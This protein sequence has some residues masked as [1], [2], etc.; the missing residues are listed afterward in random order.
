VTAVN[1]GPA[2]A[3]CTNGGPPIN[4]PVNMT[5]ACTGNL[6]QT[7]FTWALC[8][9]NNVNGTDALQTDIYDSTKGPYPQAGP[10]GGSVGANGVLQSSSL[11]VIGGTLWTAGSTGISSTGSVNV[12]EE[13]HVNGPVNVRG[14]SVGYDAFVNGAVSGGTLS[15]G[16][17]LTVPNGVTP[18]G[19][20]VVGQTIHVPPPVSVPPPC[21]CAP[22]DIIPVAT[23]VAARAMNNDD[24][25]IGLNPSIVTG[26]TGGIRLDL[27]CGEYYLN[28]IT[29]SDPVAIV[30]HGHTALYIGSNISP[31]ATL[32]ITLDPTATLDLFV[33][34]T[35]NTS[36]TLTIGN[37]NYPALSRTY[38]GGSQALTFSSGVSLGTN[39]YAPNAHLDWGAGTDIY[40]SVFSGD[41][42]GSSKVAIHYDSAVLQQ[43]SSC[44]PPPGNCSSCQQCGNQAC[45]SGMCGS[46]MNSTQCCAP[47]FCVGGT[48]TTHE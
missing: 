27:P 47:L 10:L 31:S 35:I 15:I 2:P 19:T 16:K 9:C 18:T 21:R 44:G 37:I 33:A 39:F 48:C 23:I 29:N 13:L 41:F 11:V 12:K 34:G 38:I 22:S 26:P 25:A 1:L 46:C 45:N 24:A 7:T 20:A 36:N 32:T 43:G 6:A 8:S 17:N 40:G 42:L 28:G 4:V 5:A 14:F 3:K 30:A